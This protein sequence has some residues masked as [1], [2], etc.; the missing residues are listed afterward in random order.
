[1]S[2]TC[3][4]AID[5][6]SQSTKVSIFD[7]HGRV[8]AQANVSLQPLIHYAEGKVEHPHDDLWDSLVSAC[9]N[10]MSDF[11]GTPNDIVGIG[12]CTI[13]CCRAVLRSDGSLADPVMS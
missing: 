9:Q 11:G 4:I 8:H 1:M 3:I 6:G 13:R 10:A 5:G 7:L 12:L 2:G